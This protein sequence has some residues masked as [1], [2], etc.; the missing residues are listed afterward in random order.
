V[1][2]YPVQ[3]AV[4][5]QSSIDLSG[6]TVGQLS[7][8]QGWLAAGQSGAVEATVKQSGDTNVLEFDFPYANGSHALPTIPANGKF[9]VDVT[10]GFP[11]VADATKGKAQFFL[12][13]LFDAKGKPVAQLAR[14]ANGDWN[15]RNG[16]G[17][18]E[19]PCPAPSGEW[20]TLRFEMDPKAGTY[21]GVLIDNGKAVPIFTGLALIDPSAGS[22]ASINFGR[23][24]G[25]PPDP[26]Y[27]DSVRVLF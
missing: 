16:A 12:V 23:T 7:R 8:Q 3:I 5:G 10:I 2:W 11:P 24:G 21:D 14:V 17:Y 4:A 19:A 26:V 18:S 25:G 22:A 1:G 6:L 15:A 13:Q 20:V 27:V 9:D